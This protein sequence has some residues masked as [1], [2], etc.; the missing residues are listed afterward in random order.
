MF[1]N[2]ISQALH[3]EHGATV[4]LMERLEHLLSRQRRGGAPDAA[5]P[6]VASLL[7][8]LS[9]WVNAEIERHFGFEEDR[10]FPYL[11]AAGDR[12]IGMHLT[13]EHN[14]MRPLGLALS[15]QAQEALTQGFDPARWEAFRRSAQELCE[16]MLMHVQKEEMAL[17]PL[18]DE[19]ID[20]DTEAQLYQEYVENA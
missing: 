4:A 13:E 6:A 8:D 2:R 18:L 9:G 1:A 19:S 3:D 7:N 16:R 15:A 14:A 20:P 5:D 12:A 17:L 10:L 11:A